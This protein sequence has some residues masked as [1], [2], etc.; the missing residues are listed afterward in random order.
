MIL[1]FFN[2]DVS[3]ESAQGWGLDQDGS[4]DYPMQSQKMAI[5]A[6][7]HQ[8][9]EIDQRDQPSSQLMKLQKKIEGTY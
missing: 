3:K 9:D 7:N 8:L 2:K 1:I 4:S 6:I 5:N